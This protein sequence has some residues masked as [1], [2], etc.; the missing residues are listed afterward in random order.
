MVPAAFSRDNEVQ[1]LFE[2]L[3]GDLSAATLSHR[4]EPTH[5][6]R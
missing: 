2:E 3:A 4:N 6:G 1:S 5:A